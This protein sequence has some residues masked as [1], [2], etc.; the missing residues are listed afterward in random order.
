MINESSVIVRLRLLGG[1]VFAR[2]ADRDAA[3]L[4]RIGGAGEVAAAKLKGVQGAMVGVL[5]VA[6][7]IALPLVAIGAVGGKMAMDFQQSMELIHTSAGASQRE[8]DRLSTSVLNLAKIEPQ[9]PKDLADA[10]YRLEGAGL[11]GSKA[12]KGLKAAADLAAVGNANVEDTA[13]TLSQ[14][15]FSGIKGGGNLRK[16]VAELNAT[17]GAGDLRLQQL[18]DALGVGILP[19]A[20]NAGLRLRDITGV[21]AVFGDE[22]NNVSG[23]TAQL[24]TALHYLYAPT[25]KAEKALGSIGLSGNQLGRDFR[26]PQGLLTAM[27]DLRKHLNKL[28]GGFR[29]LKAS[30][31]LSAILPGGRGRVLNVLLGQ[32]DRYQAKL[33]QVGDTTNRFGD[34]VRKTQETAAFKVKAAWSTIQ[35]ALINLGQHV[36]P[37]AAGGFTLLAKGVD[38][39]SG[40]IEALAHSNAG[41]A[42]NN[43]TKGIGKAVGVAAHGIGG[44]K[45]PAGM[46]PRAARGLGADQTQQLSTAQKAG[47]KLRSVLAPVVGWISAQLPKVGGIVMNVGKQ[48]LDAFK[49]ATPFLQNVLLPLLK[50][51]AIGVIGGVVAAF[52]VAIPVIRVVATVLGFVGRVLAPLRGIFQAVGVVIGIVFGGEILRIIGLLGKLGRVFKI[53]TIPIRI[54]NGAMR[55]IWGGLV[56]AASGFGRLLTG[57]QRFVGTFQ[58]VPARIARWMLNIVGTIVHHAETLPGKMLKVGG[59]VGKALLDGIVNAIKAAPGAITGAISSL[60]PGK[61]KGIVKKV[62]PGIATGGTVSRG[63]LAVV[64]ERGPELAD[65]PTGTRIYSADQTRRA[66]ARFSGYQ[67]IVL[68]ANLHMSGKQ[69]HHEVFKI[70]RQLAEAT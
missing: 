54:A 61:L 68:V 11:R 70:D 26:K 51:I 56:R 45:P 59:K 60:V 66:R 38:Y 14:T 58:S 65:L 49:P 27:L 39:V 34:S 10:L 1:Q 18:V 43:F 6:K 53:L 55:L 64:G 17:V 20:K 30:Q 2:E 67:P 40:R 32:L 44:P 37:I 48:I 19:V 3:A 31:T 42:I 36:L 69:I 16:V 47:L 4:G 5:G 23:W 12:M 29:G 50:G 57:V 46:S 9:S 15:W 22:T 7:K 35:V 52:K 63:G 33:K 8:V 21:M 41:R 24:A 28:P 25:A 62:I 13:K